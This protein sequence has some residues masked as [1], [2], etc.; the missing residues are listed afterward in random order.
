METGYQRSK[1]QEES[2]HYETLKHD[3][4]LPIVGVN[5]FQNPHSE[6]DEMG[7]FIELARATEDEKAAQLQRVRDFVKRT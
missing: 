2:I 7:A 3:G 5:T 4:R 6:F 1:I